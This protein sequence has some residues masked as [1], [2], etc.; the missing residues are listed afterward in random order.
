MGF[1]LLELLVVLAVFGFILAVLGSGVRFASRAV[2]SADRQRVA[3]DDLDPVQAAIRALIGDARA[4]EGSSDE[5]KFVGPMPEALGLR[6]SFD[7]SLTLSD[8]RLVAR[9]RPHHAKGDAAKDDTAKDDADDDPPGTHG[10]AELAHGITDLSFAYYVAGSDGKIGW[11]STAPK[12][13]GLRLVRVDATLIAGDHRHWPDLVVAP[14]IDT[15][16]GP[17]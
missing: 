14:G 16:Q 13:S 5:I 10:E 17:S 9:W 7:I 3:H 2:Q 11:H 4:I 12:R 6:G 8:E 1:T 15:A